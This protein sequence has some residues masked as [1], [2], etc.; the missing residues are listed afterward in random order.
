MGELQAGQGATGVRVAAPVTGADLRLWGWAAISRG[1]RAIS[2]YAWYPMSSGYES[3]GYGMIELD[4]TVTERAKIAGEFAGVVAR[5]A[6]LFAPM[7]PRPSRVAILYNR[8]SYMVGGNTVA[9]GHARPQLD[10][11]D[12]PRAVR[13]EHPGGL[14]SSRRDRRRAGLEVRRRLSELS[15]DAA[16]AGG[17]CA[18]GLRARRRHAHQRSTPGVEQRARPREHA[19]PGRGT[20]RGVRRAREGAAVPGGRD[21]YRREGSRRAPGAARRPDLQR[22]GICRAPRGHGP[23]DARA[24]ALSG[25]RKRSRGSGDRHVALRHR[26]GRY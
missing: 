13:A 17:R 20:G 2:Y 12:L 8:L 11:R 25:G 6:A 24:G 26:A 21:V 10:A 16:A 18:Q 7:R 14:H 22:A 4:G 5:N 23:V 19:H 15:A 3:N 9:P 1:V